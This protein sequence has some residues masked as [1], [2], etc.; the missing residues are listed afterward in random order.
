MD[1]A[2]T[3]VVVDKPKKKYNFKKEKKMKAQK[4]EMLKLKKLG[5]MFVGKPLNS[6]DEKNVRE[7]VERKKSPLK[8]VG[9]RS[10]RQE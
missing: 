6:N 3:Q 8:I 9:K 10:Q 5:A 4:V 2:Q 1:L 7:I